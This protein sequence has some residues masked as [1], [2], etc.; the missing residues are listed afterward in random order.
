MDRKIT[1][2]S[3]NLWN[4]YFVE[5][6]LK[7]KVC[8]NFILNLYQF[9]KKRLQTMREKI[10]KGL[11]PID[12]RGSHDNHKKIDIKIWVDLYEF[13]SNIPSKPSHYKTPKID[14]LFFNESN[15]SI[16]IIF[17]RFNEFYFEKNNIHL[18]IS[19]KSFYN[20]FKVNCNYGFKTLQIDK[21][22]TCCKYETKNLS[23]KEFEIHIQKI[24][25]FKI[26]RQN[27]FNNNNTLC[28][29]FDYS[30]NKPFPKL[31]CNKGFYSRAMFLYLFN[32]FIHKFNYNFI[33]HSIEGQYIKG[34]NSVCSY[35][36][37]VID[38]LRFNI[39]FDNFDT[40]VFI[41]D[42]CGGQNKNI[43]FIHFCQYI[44]LLLDIKVIHIFPIVG[45]TY[46]ICDTHFGSIGKKCKNLIIELPN[47]YLNIIKNM[48]KFAVIS[49]AVLNYDIILNNLFNS[50]KNINI[51]KLRRIDY[52]PYGRINYSYDYN[53]GLNTVNLL[54][55]NIQ[56]ILNSLIS[57]PNAPKGVINIKKIKDIYKLLDYLDDNKK[58]FYINYLQSF[59]I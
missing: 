2:K 57:V 37:Y 38:W 3:F 44:S 32:V 11:V 28:I 7:T 51:S 58:Q 6:G 1:N 22:N 9:S 18:N 47:D 4:Y 8:Q 54:K 42:N 49:T 27:L 10:R 43:N 23:L 19:Y 17:N 45:H 5:N 29:S 25:E 53:V 14:K 36:Y 20:Y 30:A 16:N 59:E 33:F 46:S 24:N 31:N 13:L 15:L 26:L 55:F 35:L 50:L 39:N 48:N 21:C 41:S 56:Y 12:N 40:L 34:S 52:S